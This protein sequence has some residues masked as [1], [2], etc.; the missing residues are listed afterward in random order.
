MQR[1]ETFQCGEWSACS[2]RMVEI[3]LNLKKTI[4]LYQIRV[5]SRTKI[6]QHS[7]NN[8]N[9]EVVNSYQHQDNDDM[10][11]DVEDSTHQQPLSADGGIGPG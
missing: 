6:S 11:H 8:V 4:V 3:I 9:H 10:N 7:E 1:P 2:D 5:N